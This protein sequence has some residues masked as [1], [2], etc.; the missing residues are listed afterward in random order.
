MHPGLSVYNSVWFASSLAWASLSTVTWN[1]YDHLTVKEFPA[2]VIQHGVQSN[3]GSW[4]EGHEN[5]N[6]EVFI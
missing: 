5:V 6:S 1:A 4:K 3:L 2:E